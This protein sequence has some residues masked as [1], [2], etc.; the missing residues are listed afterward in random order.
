MKL[1]QRKLKL[2]VPLHI[3]NNKIIL[4][5]YDTKPNK[6]KREN[7]HFSCSNFSN[8]CSYL[9]SSSEAILYVFNLFSQNRK[10]KLKTICNCNDPT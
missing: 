10:M 9:G 7:K 5:V 1:L 4:Y 3:S 8:G 2:G 6:S